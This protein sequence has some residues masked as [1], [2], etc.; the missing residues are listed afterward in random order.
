MEI[1]ALSSEAIASVHADEL[2]LMPMNLK[3]R[4]Y[5]QLVGE[6][7]DLLAR[8]INMPLRLQIGSVL[9]SHVVHITRQELDELK[10][11]SY[12]LVVE[13]LFQGKSLRVKQFVDDP[14]T[15]PEI[16]FY[17]N[18]PTGTTT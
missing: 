16:E 7:P 5:A 1:L 3:V 4:G 2:T 6:N 9:I 8:R 17:C 13:I 15:S 14:A 12:G 18:L 10:F 11:T